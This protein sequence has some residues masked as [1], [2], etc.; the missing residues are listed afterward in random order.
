MSK[1]SDSGKVTQKAF[2]GEIEAQH[3]YAERLVESGS[4]FSIVVGD[5]FVRGMRDIGYKHTGTAID[6]L[7][8]NAMQAGGKTVHIAFGYNGSQSKPSRI[9]VIDDGH[10]MC[11]TMLRA[12]VL[13]GGTHREGDRTGFGRYGYGLPSSCVSQGKCFEVFSREDKG[14][15]HRVVIDLDEITRGGYRSESGRICVPEPKRDELPDW[16]REYLT[17]SIEEDSLQHGTVVIIENLDRL[18]WVTTNALQR[19]LLQ[20]FGVTYRN[21]LRDVRLLVNACE[22]EPVDPLFTTPGLKFYDIDEDR[23]ESLEPLV[24]DVKDP[25]SGKPQGTVR[26]RYSYMPPTFGRI[27]EDKMKGRGGKNNPRFNI[28]K[29]HNGLIIMRAGRQ[30]D[31]V[32][33]PRQLKKAEDG[34][35]FD[36]TFVNND[37]YW[38]VEIDFPPTLDEEFT[39]TTSKQQIVL[40]ARIVDHLN[41]AGVFKAISQMRSRF[42]LENAS[43]KTAKEKMEREKRASEEA[44]EETSRMKPQKPAEKAREQ[45]EEGE[46]NLKKEARK[47]SRQTGRSESD[48]EEEIRQ[49]ILGQAYKVEEEDLPGAPFFRVKQRGGQAVLFINRCHRFYTDTYAGPES[50]SRLRAAME[51]LLFVI[52]ECELDAGKG[53][54]LRAFYERERNRWSTNLSTALDRL[55]QI[56]NIEDEES[57]KDA[58]AEHEMSESESDPEEIAAS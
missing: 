16:I 52:G 36:F 37:R 21:F 20:H 31:V 5:A 7:I 53:T 15:F 11:A 28:M 13:W 57:A 33:S 27:P 48:V 49:E 46:E 29:E 4:D 14:D 35:K 22:V 9:A 54:P 43:L 56:D 2:V 40:S 34:S 1:K 38:G 51:I 58:Q 24:F 17:K 10:G 8:D 45:I 42:D 55:N 32:S 3:S 26:V 25:E 47:R 6:E 23:A 44:M 39:V 30:I 50:N 19:E 12:S 18:T 41:K